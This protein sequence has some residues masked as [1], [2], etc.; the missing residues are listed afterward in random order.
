MTLLIKVLFG[1]IS[2]SLKECL[3]WVSCIRTVN[4]KISFL[5]NLKKKPSPQKSERFSSS[6]SYPILQISLTY[7]TY[8]KSCWSA[9][10]QFCGHEDFWSL[11]LLY[12]T[13]QCSS[14]AR[15]AVSK[16]LPLAPVVDL[17]FA[18]RSQHSL[19]STESINWPLQCHH[20]SE[21]SHLNTVVNN[22]IPLEQIRFAK[23]RWV[24]AYLFGSLRFL[25][26]GSKL[27]NEIP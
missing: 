13:W 9:A 25:E 16:H 1:F 20:S 19:R 11:D 5:P 15:P 4:L 22:Y 12:Q 24:L 17:D 14:R 7:P 2:S 6:T 8:P 27:G 26:T 21:I 10:T 3:S 18:N 23:Q